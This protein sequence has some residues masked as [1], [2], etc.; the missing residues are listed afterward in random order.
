MLSFINKVISLVLVPVYM[1]PFL[2]FLHIAKIFNQPKDLIS[3]SANGIGSDA[4][5]V[6]LTAH[7]GVSAVAPENSLPSFEA[8]VKHGYYTAECDIHLTKDNKW[9]VCHNSEVD[10]RFCEF[11]KISDL[12][13]DEVR[14]FSYK[15][16][17]NFWKYEDMRIPTLDEYLDVFVGT[18]TRPQIEIKA[19]TYDMLYTV[20]D[21]VVAKG[22]ESSAIVISF[23]LEQLKKI[24]ELNSNIE[25]WY[26]IDEITA[27]NI[28]EAKSIGDNVWLSPNFERNNKDTIQLAIDAGIGVS[29][30]TVNTVEDAKMLYDMGIRYIETDIL[31]K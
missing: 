27:E 2:P 17:A 7:R 28:A 1:C 16:G 18:A 11:G 20:V 15:S 4:D 13:F 31:C 9:V 5:P 21:A 30:W 10:A 6:F 24:H 12:T 23:D 22:L 8:A 14:S 19:E 3:L 26:L 29:F 25:L